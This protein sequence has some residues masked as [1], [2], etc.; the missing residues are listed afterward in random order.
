M[1]AIAKTDPGASETRELR[2]QREADRTTSL[3]I[4]EDTLGLLEFTPGDESVRKAGFEA[5]N[6]VYDYFGI[7]ATPESALSEVVG[8]RAP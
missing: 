5:A 1:A 2:T 7:D 8:L 4:P 6:A 3:P